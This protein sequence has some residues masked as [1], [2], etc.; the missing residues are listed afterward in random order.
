M[1]VSGT[2]STKPY[3]EISNFGEKVLSFC[4]QKFGIIYK[5]L[6]HSS[7]FTEDIGNAV[8]ILQ[9]HIRDFLRDQLCRG[10]EKI[11]GVIDPS[12]GYQAIRHLLDLRSG[13][14]LDEH[15]I[16]TIFLGYLALITE[17][18]IFLDSVH[19]PVPKYWF[20]LIWTLVF[21]E[22]LKSRFAEGWEDLK[23]EAKS[24]CDECPNKEDLFEELKLVEHPYAEINPMIE[25]SF[26][27]LDPFFLF[28]TL[29][30][31]LEFP[32]KPGLSKEALD[33]LL[34]N[35]DLRRTIANARALLDSE[36]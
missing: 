9:L 30:T 7:L 10:V 14:S 27:E 22:R 21:E 32:R 26:K 4:L 12:Q 23:A 35:P 8:V 24:V 11:V 29:G 36:N 3:L 16:H 13:Q 28:C 1:A 31:G 20:T 19:I 25:T 18:I 34:Q 33:K 2:V 6:A 5:D 17:L 15:P